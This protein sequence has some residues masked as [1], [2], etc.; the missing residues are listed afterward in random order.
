MA[1]FLF[2]EENLFYYGKGVDI[3][4]IG[5]LFCQELLKHLERKKKFLM[6]NYNRVRNIDEKL[7]I[8]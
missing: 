4:T 5:E 6:K 3:M 7:N 2:R 8:A 1:L